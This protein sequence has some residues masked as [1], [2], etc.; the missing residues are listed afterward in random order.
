MIS[1]NGINFSERPGSCGTCPYFTFLS[2][3]PQI[4]KGHCILWNEIHHSYINPPVKCQK[5][6]NKVFKYPDGTEFELF[7]WKRD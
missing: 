4:R 2:P 3:S 1:I 6:F 7:E 5:L